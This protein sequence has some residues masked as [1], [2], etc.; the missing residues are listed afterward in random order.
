LAPARQWPTPWW[1]EPSG[2]AFTPAKRYRFIDTNADG[3][4]DLLL[5]FNSRRTGIACGDT[6]ASL[7]G[8]TRDGR[9]I[10]G[11]DA[12]VTRKCRR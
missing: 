8:E 6:S 3:D 12:I 9:Q 10:E 1:T 5:F 4:D 7:S 2:F 11:S